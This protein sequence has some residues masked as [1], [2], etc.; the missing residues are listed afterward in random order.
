[1]R[2][3]RLTRT[4][5][6]LAALVAL[7][8]GCGGGNGDTGSAPSSK[9]QVVNISDYTYRPANLT[10]AAGTKITFL[11]R[12]STAHTAT[13]KQRGSFDTEPI[14][15]GQHA[16]VTFNEP[17]TFVYYCVFHPFMKGTVKVE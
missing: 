5:T 15:P 11:N 12:D 2:A 17:G 13:S 3:V 8:G 9:A 10:V 1:M 7:A 6:A 4:L 14:Q 16:T